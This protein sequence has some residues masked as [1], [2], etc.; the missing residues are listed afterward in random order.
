MPKKTKNN[1]HLCVISD[2]AELSRIRDFI[3]RKTRLLGISESI[4]YDISLAVD[5]ACSNLIKHAYKLE[6]DRKIC[7]D[8]ETENNKLIVN[9]LDNGVPFN[10]MD[11]PLQDMSEY[12]KQLKHG[13]LGI[14]IMRSV[15]DEILYI[16][17]KNKRS[18][19]TLRLIKNI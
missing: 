15:I 16:P 10:P 4:A 1:D 5:E 8:V 7:I 6:K 14:H 2:L 13:G 11:V 3:L 18:H 19:N 17:R 12:L 9:I